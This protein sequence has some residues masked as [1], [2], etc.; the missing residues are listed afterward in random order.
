M[1]VVW[2]CLEDYD[3]DLDI[4]HFVPAFREYK[5]A[6]S[7]ELPVITVNVL[8][9]LQ[10]P[11]LPPIHK[12][13]IPEIPISQKSF[14]VETE[15]PSSYNGYKLGNLPEIRDQY[16]YG[17]C[18]A[19][20]AIAAVEADLIHDGNADTGIDLSE[21]HLA[22][23]TNHE[24]FDEK[25]LNTG[26][27]IIIDENVEYLNAGGNDMKASFALFNM[28]GPVLESYVPYGS[29]S[30]Y[31]P[32]PSDGRA[33][34]Y[35]ITG[36]YH[37]SSLSYTDNDWTKTA[38][39]EHG[40]VTAAYWDDDACYSAANN[41]Y[42][43]PQ[44][45]GTNHAIAIVGWDDNFS[46]NKFRSG[47]TPPGDGAW[48]IRNSWG[49]NDY[50]RGGYF[51]LSYYDNSLERDKYAFDVQPGRYDHVY[52]YDNSPGNAWFIASPDTV[53]LSFFVDAGEKIQA[54]GF[55][56][57]DT[58][59]SLL[60]TV[61]SGDSSVTQTFTTTDAGYYLIP[62]SNPLTISEKSKVTVEYTITGGTLT[63]VPFETALYDAYD[64]ETGITYNADAGSEGLVLDGSNTGVDGRI[65]LFTNSLPLTTAVTI[66]DPKGTNITGDTKT[67]DSVSYQLKAVAA[68]FSALQ[69]FTWTS[70]DKTTAA[71]DASGKVTFRKP[72]T[73]TITAAAADGSGKSASVT[74]I[75]E[76]SPVEAVAIQ[77]A[78]GADITGKTVT[79]HTTVYQLKAVAEPPAASQTFTWKSSNTNT[80]AVGS[81]GKVAFKKA[82]TVTITAAADDGSG[83][84]A[85]VKLT[86]VPLA[87]AVI[88]QDAAGNNVTG[89]TVAADSRIVQLRA[90]ATPAE[91]AQKF[92]W[93]G[94]NNT[95]G[96]VDSSGKVSLKKGGN[97]T[98][99]AAAA[100][101]SKKSAS[102]T[103]SYDPVRCFVQRCYDL[104]LLRKADQ[105]GLTYY[106]ERLKSGQLTGA[107][108]VMNY[109]NSPEFQGKKYSNEKVVEILYLTMMDRTADANGRNYWAQFLN[110]GL[111]QKYVVRGFAGS[112]EFRNICS[113]YGITAG[114]LTL[115][116][117]RDKNPKVTA[118]VSRNYSIALGRKGDA[119]GLN[120]WTGMIL[121]KKLTPQQV[122]D[123]FVFSKE[124]VSKNLNNT[125]FVKM[126]Y[127]LYMGREYDQGGLNY[128]LQQMD[129][130]MTRQTV[131]KSFGG[132]KEFRNIVA[133]Y[134][135]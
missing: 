87:A 97:V 72:G 90:A 73:V 51:W 61:S 21:L 130:G 55:Y 92:T 80:A 131:A 49:V 134:G 82:G 37:Y 11:P 59:L 115:T 27:T 8:G 77:D 117:N 52:S 78:N 122:A 95:V 109:I 66:H 69:T 67:I 79:I 84:S 32:D 58:N 132:S 48:L 86:Y 135:L 28:L 85:T 19:H 44:A 125:E 6:E 39:M 111:S 31:S 45:P 75:C 64:E 106:M 10:K 103:I 15:I 18:W 13:M 12:E 93:S 98:I 47:A 26:D 3:E 114:M 20:A 60:F 2:K 74:L 113:T 128:W 104:I 129:K 120:Y 108:M 7:L 41:S 91:A 101:G 34:D 119:D 89:Q 5:F 123:S 36:Y 42:Y 9:K 4:F 25:G 46:R 107:Q 62:L 70:S 24:F 56:T 43:N 94:S 76:L 110:D 96:T 71:V 57:F 83:K 30:T 35:Q 102:V 53:S 14:D 118:F 22:Y 29:A 105:G 100:D 116:E 121:T 81:T 16:P 23:F 127:R 68:P 88:I 63:K 1:D 65:K 133:S 126:L 50:D 33:G 38:I 124:C 40:A 112:A 17:T 99:T 54:L